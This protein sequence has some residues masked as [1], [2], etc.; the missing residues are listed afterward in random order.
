MKVPCELAN[1]ESIRAYYSEGR[2]LIV[3]T[4]KV[5][6]GERVDIEL[7]NPPTTPLE[8]KLQRCPKPG[9]WPAVIVPYTYE[10][11]F[12]IT[13]SPDRV[14]IAGTIK[15]HHQDGVDE[16][17]LEGMP[18]E[19]APFQDTLPAAGEDQATGYSRNLS[20]DEAFRDALEN[21]GPGDP[22]HPDALTRMK[23]D[24]VG[25]LFG[26]LAGF[27]RLY[28]KVTRTVGKVHPAQD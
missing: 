19:L 15:V 3:A 7:V 14:R 18:E 21:L 22:A 2:L 27:H 6:A 8:F 17:S 26:G 16:V 9:I 25:A 1:R 13:H 12:R 4:G 23:V 10:E 24:E 11:T 5:G 20:F 28:V